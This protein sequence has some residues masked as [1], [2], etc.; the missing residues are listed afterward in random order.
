LHLFSPH[1]STDDELR[2]YAHKWCGGSLRNGA[3]M[4]AS[5]SVSDGKKGAKRGQKKAGI[6]KKRKKIEKKFDFGLK[7]GF[8][9]VN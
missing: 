2:T 1:F 7:K 4:D 8:D 6:E 9:R 5:F 3:F